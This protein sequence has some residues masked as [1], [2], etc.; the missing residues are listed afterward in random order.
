MLPFDNMLNE[1]RKLSNTLYAFAETKSQ[2][3]RDDPA[4]LVLVTCCL[5]VSTIGFATV[6]NLRFFQFVKLLFYM[7][8]I[9][10]IAA[11][12]LITTI[13]W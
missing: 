4:F 12:L 10:Y 3:A 8:F 7:V 6:L 11:G 5:C 1:Y 9:D 13:F 2:F